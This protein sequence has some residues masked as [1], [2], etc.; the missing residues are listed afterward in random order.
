[1]REEKKVLTK[2][3]EQKRTIN[4]ALFKD[5]VI[6]YLFNYLAPNDSS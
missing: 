4:D 6:L 2:Y 5:E 1:M 3:G